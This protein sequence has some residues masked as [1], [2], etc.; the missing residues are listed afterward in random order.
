MTCDLEVDV[1]GEETFFVSKEILSSF[2]NRIKSLFTTLPTVEPVTFPLKVILH[3]FPGGAE[4]FELFVQYCY[5]FGN[6]QMTPCN[7]L[8]LFCAGSFMETSETNLANF[9]E[10]LESIQTWSW[11]DLVTGLKQCQEIFPL[12]ETLGLF[13]KVAGAILEKVA[14]SNDT[15]PMDASP[16]SSMNRFSCDTKSTIST[17][18]GANSRNWWFEDLLF[19]KPKFLER[20]VRIMVLHK[21]DH[22]ITARF[23]FY[24]VKSGLSCFTIEEKKLAIEATIGL[25]DSLNR[26]SLSCRGLFGILSVSA[27]LKINITHRDKLEAMIGCK[28][29]QAT[30]DNLLI[31]APIGS[32]SLYDVN[33]VLRFLGYFS[34]SIMCEVIPRL[35]K[36]G[37]L[38]DLYLAEVTPDP[39][40][41][42][43]KF[44]E[45]TSALP[46]LARD[47]HDSLYRAIDIFFQ[48]HSR[49]TEEEKTKICCSISYEK[50]TSDCCKQLTKNPKFPPRTAIR[51]LA[52]QHS[53]L[54]TLL[55]EP[56]SQPLNSISS[57]YDEDQ[58][59][60]YAKRV[61]LTMENE[62]LKA[63]LEGMHWRVMELE[64]IC[65]K[66]KGQMANMKNTRKHSSI[67][68]RSSLPRLCS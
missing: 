35:K 19:L 62:N 61:D 37:S 50:L 34:K 13:E 55:H 57:N 52:S 9:R 10:Y 66:L 39:A 2:S 22:G 18:N 51:A 47:C 17:K 53:M 20:V 11:F 42:P 48:V 32:G 16:D 15:T 1:N 4:A 7:I 28:I 8:P 46:P 60:L 12:S 23:L 44:A 31:P 3:E 5:S 56:N 59:I 64:K 33:L 25:L 38:M 40:L 6:F 24:Y 65:G 29:Y 41:K 58:V 30:L 63:V 43:A 45:L 36:V 54:K 68:C 14:F 26:E 67:V 21:F 27:P 49:L